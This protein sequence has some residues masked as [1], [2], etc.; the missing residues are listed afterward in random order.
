MRRVVQAAGILGAT[1]VMAGAFGAHALRSLVDA[2]AQGWWETAARYQL[3]HAVVLLALGVANLPS[4]RFVGLA[5][6]CLIGGILV[7]SGTLYAMALGGPR[8]LGAITPIGGSLLI[9]GWILIVVAAS[10]TR[11]AAARSTD[12]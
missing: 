5:A 12:S 10:A 3:I 4:T 11:Q 7:F 2:Q 9:A 1:G 8:M 6:R